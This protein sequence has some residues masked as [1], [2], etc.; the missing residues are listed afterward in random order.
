MVK[1][2]E[3]NVVFGEAPLSALA[4]K[5][6]I[7]TKGDLYVTNAADV[8]AGKFSYHQSGVTHQYL[9][10]TQRRS[11]TGKP[12]KEK[13]PEIKGFNQSCLDVARTSES[14]RL[15]TE[16]RHE[17]QEGSESTYARLGLVSHGVVHRKR[18]KRPGREDY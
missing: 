4:A 12:P 17:N 13:L 7:E 10:I 5:I 6:W 18:P 1:L 14:H 3:I 16:G 15:S 11:G 9:N 2:L 8:L